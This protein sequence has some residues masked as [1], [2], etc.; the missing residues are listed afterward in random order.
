MDS[1]DFLDIMF[2]LESEFDMKIRDADFDR[3]LRPDKSE[4]ALEGEFLTDE[5]INRLA[6]IIPLLDD[7]AKIKKVPRSD[8][9]SFVTVETLVTMVNRKVMQG[10]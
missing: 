7:A 10:S 8:L 3:V 2:C 1:L 5:E 6:P 4:A 9:F